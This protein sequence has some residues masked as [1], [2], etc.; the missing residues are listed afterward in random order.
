[1][2]NSYF[3]R[4][5]LEE[6]VKSILNTKIDMNN[7]LHMDEGLVA[8]PGMKVKIDKYSSTGAVEDVA[9]NNGNSQLIESSYTSS[10]YEVVVTQGK[11]VYT[12]EEAMRNPIVVDTLLKGVAETMVN[13]AT[14]KAIAEM[15]KAEKVIECDFTTNT[16]GYFFG[17][18]VDA[19]AL[20]GE[21][22]DEGFTL[23]INPAQQ[24]YARKQLIDSLQYSGDFA[25]TGYIGS[26]AGVP[27]V[28]SNAVPAGC[29][30]IVSPE[31]ITYF[32]KK[33]IEIETDR[34]SDKRQ[35]FIYVRK[36]GLAAFTNA[37]YLVALAKAQATACV[38]TKPS[39][40]ATT[41]AGTCGTDVDKVI[42]IDGH[43]KKYEAIPSAGAWTVTVDAV[44]TGDK[45]NA[46]AIAYGFAPKAA[47][48][49]TV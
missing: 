7:Y 4:E 11:A 49:V 30:F 32:A 2:A 29:A 43:G 33:G 34:D 18:V 17:K 1:M 9:E 13:D 42:L 14:A 12:D 24:A 6:K 25:R 21:H 8:E 45:L 35:N 3:S 47:T 31:A 19:L 40:G 22:Q 15:S 10:E 39:N 26:V 23:L 44:A 48:E 20:L 38:I 28:V 41:V 27:V 16:A 37:D 46:T 5:L 36:V